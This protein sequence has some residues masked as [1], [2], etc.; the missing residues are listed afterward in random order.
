MK[1]MF[2][3]FTAILCALPLPVLA[4]LARMSSPDG[5]MDAYPK[6][7]KE[8]YDT[9]K[10]AVYYDLKYLKDSTKTG[11]YT[12]AKTVLQLSDKYAKYGDYH[13]LVLDSLD[14][15]KILQ[16]KRYRPVNI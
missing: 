14:I 3:V 15:D 7:R 10:I 6:V 5:G 4:Q 8:V 2:S 13:Q 16:R 9:A 1:L 11:E 12:K